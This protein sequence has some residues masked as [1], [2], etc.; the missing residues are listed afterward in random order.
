MLLCELGAVARW[1]GFIMGW[2][3]FLESLFA[4]IGTAL[5]AGGYVAF[6]LN[7]IKPNLTTTT[8]AAVACTVVFCCWAAGGE[9]S[10]D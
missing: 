10:A 7:P 8:V 4:A 6:L 3:M 5:A 2:S 9:W 1:F